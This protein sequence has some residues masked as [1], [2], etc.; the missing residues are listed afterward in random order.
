MTHTPGFED[1]ATDGRI[2][3]RNS[4]DIMPLGEYLKDK[5]PARVRP[6]GEVTAYSNYGSAL[7][8]YIVAQVS[9]MPFDKYVEENIL[10][11][12]GMRNT[13]F[14]QPLPPELSKNMSLGYTYASGGFQ[15]E[16]FE[17]RADLARRLHEFHL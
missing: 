5:M 14:E 8:A 11:P 10:L 17:V 9:G 15:A 2:F 4:T 12:L 16:P 6:P 3:V 13:T 7:A 1:L